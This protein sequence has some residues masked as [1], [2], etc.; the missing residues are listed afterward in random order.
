MCAKSL[1]SCSALCNLTD[2]SL[3]GSSVHGF[4]QARILEWV[5]MPSSRE[6]SWPRDPTRVS[7]TAGEFF[8]I[9]ATSDTAKVGQK[10]VAQAYQQSGLRS[11]EPQ[12]YLKAAEKFCSSTQGYDIARNQQKAEDGPAPLNTPQEW[13]AG[14]KTEQR[15]VTG[16]AH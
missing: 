13:G 14:Q 8:T 11:G 16:K 7:W 4:L 3:P 1:Q 12:M 15:F 5:T 9:W 2:Y 6:S 10:R